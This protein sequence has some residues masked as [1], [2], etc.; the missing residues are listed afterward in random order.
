MIV[1]VRSAPDT[2]EGKRGVKI[3]RDLSA[4][5]VLVQNGVY[6]L[7]QEKLEDLGFAGTAYA[8]EDDMRLRGLKIDGEKTNTKNISYDGLVDLMTERD[9][10]VG[11]F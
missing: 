7:R 10:V 1:I 8:L 5:I 11:M 4:D 3:A 6:F 2:A 9:K